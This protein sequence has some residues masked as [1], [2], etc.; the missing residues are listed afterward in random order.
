MVEQPRIA[1]ELQKMEYEPL[2][3]VE[4]KMVGWSI[5]LGITLLFVLYGLSA[6]LGLAQ[7]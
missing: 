7:P 4:K 2:L 1:E 3:P 5:G 6:F